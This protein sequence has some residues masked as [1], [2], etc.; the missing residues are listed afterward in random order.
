[1]NYVSQRVARNSATTGF[2]YAPEYITFDAMTK[3]KLTDNVDLQLNVYNLF[4][5]EYLDLLHP[6]HSVPGAGRTVMLTTS[7][8]M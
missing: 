6:S 8:K 3:Y 1:M 5:E 7:F 2:E 4:D